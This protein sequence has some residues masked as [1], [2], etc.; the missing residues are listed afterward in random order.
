MNQIEQYEMMIIPVRCKNCKHRP[1]DEE[2]YGISED[3][4]FPDDVCPFQCDDPWYSQYPADDFFCAKGEK[5][6]E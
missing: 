2:G 3:L 6:N 4:V 1:Y 5:I